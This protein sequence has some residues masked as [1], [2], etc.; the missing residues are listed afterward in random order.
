MVSSS[1]WATVTKMP[2]TGWLINNKHLFLS[3]LE[4]EE[5]KIKA[6]DNLVSVEGLLSHRQC[7]VLTW[8]KGHGGLWDLSYEGTDLI[9]EG[10]AF[11]M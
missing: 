7:R 5:S 11:K 8:W 2:S 3:V 6:L 1:V 9:H 10:T 4:A